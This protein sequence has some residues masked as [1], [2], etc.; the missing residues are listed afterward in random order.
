VAEKAPVCA[1]R[2]K[3]T[4]NHASKCAKHDDYP[5]VYQVGGQVYAVQVC[6]DLGTLE[7]QKVQDNK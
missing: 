5:P 6:A 4:R 1:N 2:V 3:Q 7:A